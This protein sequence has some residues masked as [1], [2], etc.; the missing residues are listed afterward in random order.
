MLRRRILSA[1]RVNRLC[2]MI[3]LCIVYYNIINAEW[4][5]YIVR[6]SRPFETIRYRLWR[7]DVFSSSQPSP[8]DTLIIKYY[9]NEYGKYINRQ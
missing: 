8:Q 4:N 5:N 9:L 2:R 1:N 7:T 3:L 6:F